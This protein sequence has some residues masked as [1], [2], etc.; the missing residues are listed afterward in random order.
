VQVADPV[1]PVQAAALVL[2][3]LL[4]EVPVAPPT[5]AQRWAELRMEGRRQQ[6]LEGKQ[7]NPNNGSTGRLADCGASE[8]KFRRWHCLQW[9]PNRIAGLWCWLS[10]TPA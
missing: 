8:P 10:G 5:R 7:P 9:R 4:V 3:R 6:Q 2:V 1:V